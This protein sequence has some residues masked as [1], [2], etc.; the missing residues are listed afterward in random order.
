MSTPA[1]AVAVSPILRPPGFNTQPVTLTLSTI[2]IN[3]LALAVPIT[4]L[5]VYDRIVRNHSI[6]TLYVLVAGVCLAVALDVA[7]R[8]SRSYLLGFTGAAYVHRMSVAA[9]THVVNTETRGS[10][11]DN[12][13][14]GLSSLTAIRSLR[15]FFNGHALTVAIDLCFVPVYLAVIWYIGGSIVLIPLGVV[16]VFALMSGYM[17]RLLKLH[18]VARRVLDDKRYDF[19]IRTLDAVHSVKAFAAEYLQLRIYEAFHD[20]SCRANHGCRRS[21]RARST[22]PALSLRSWTRWSSRTGPT[23]PSTAK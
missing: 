5:Q 22:T 4:T 14:K 1:S 20:R 3:V 7:L 15:D 12:V 11:S 19:L 18:L 8:M 16:V 6:E 23:S 13:A 2:A 10:V 17:G 9:I 21:R